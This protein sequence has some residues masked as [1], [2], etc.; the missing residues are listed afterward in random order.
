VV[1]VIVLFLRGGGMNR[2]ERARTAS[3][4]DKRGVTSNNYR[5]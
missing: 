1:V 5:R 3:E 4:N 2:E